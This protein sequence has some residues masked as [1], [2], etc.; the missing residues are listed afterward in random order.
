M[1]IMIPLYITKTLTVMFECVIGVHFEDAP[2]IDD[3]H[4]RRYN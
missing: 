3:R 1:M 4:D 2:Q